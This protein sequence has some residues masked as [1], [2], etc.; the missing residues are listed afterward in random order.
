M[1][2]PYVLLSVPLPEKD[3]TRVADS[4]NSL[5]NGIE[6]MARELGDRI[7]YST[8]IDQRSQFHGDP[9]NPGNYCYTLRIDAT[10]DSLEDL[11][12][13]AEIFISQLRTRAVLSGG[14]EAAKESIRELTS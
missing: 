10:S 5:N 1:V 11:D 8:G 12:R 7:N 6:Q 13:A 9:A 3:P 2:N 14:S 4:I